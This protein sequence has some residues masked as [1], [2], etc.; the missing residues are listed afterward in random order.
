VI[1]LEGEY[2]RVTEEEGEF[3]GTG[4]ESGGFICDG[5]AGKY[6]NIEQS[7]VRAVTYM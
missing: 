3:R 4:V 2:G 5:R 6:Y 7:T 1:S